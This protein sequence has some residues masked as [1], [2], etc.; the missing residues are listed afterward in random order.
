MT[1][2]QLSYKGV[3]KSLGSKLIEFCCNNSGISLAL[4]RSSSSKRSFFKILK[5]VT[6]FYIIAGEGSKMLGGGILQKM[7]QF[8]WNGSST[9]PRNQF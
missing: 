1:L 6:A 7:H 2:Y 5:M 4:P 8:C 9:T 3:Q